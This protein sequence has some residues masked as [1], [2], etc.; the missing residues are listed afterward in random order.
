MLRYSSFWCCFIHVI[1]CHIALCATFWNG[2]Q[3][4][5]LQDVYTTQILHCSKMLCFVIFSFS[6]NFSFFHLI[7]CQFL[8]ICLLNSKLTTVQTRWKQLSCCDSLDTKPLTYCTANFHMWNSYSSPLQFLF[9]SK[10]SLQC[11]S[12]ISNV[13]MICLYVHIILH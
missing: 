12:F 1:S 5:I 8:M 7:L 9:R 3:S 4:C 2:D 13:K 11:K 6:N 10:T